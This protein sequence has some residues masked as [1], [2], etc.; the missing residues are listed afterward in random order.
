VEVSVPGWRVFPSGALRLDLAALRPHQTDP[1]GY[2]RALGAMLFADEAAGTAYRETLA[3]CQARGTAMRV[4]LRLDPPALHD[5]HWER[6]YAPTADDWE[7]LAATARTPFARSLPAQGWERPPLVTRRPLR[8]LAVIA[9]PAGLE[10]FDLDPIAEAERAALRATLEGLPGVSVTYLETGTARPATLDA[11]RAALA[12]G[13]HLVHLLCHGAARPDGT[14]LYLDGAAGLDRVKRERLLGCFA[15]VAQRPLFCFIAAC[16][17]AR[18][19]RVDG[20]MPL[21][22]ALVRDGSVQ[23]AVAMADRV[24]VATA[25][26]FTTHFY[27]RLLTHGLLDVAT[28]EA[29]ALVQDAWDWGVPVLFSRLPDNQ[30]LDFPVSHIFPAATAHTDRAMDA[31][32]RALAIARG[33]ADGATGQVVVQGLRALLLELS[34]SHKALADVASRL[35]AVSNAADD[36]GPRFEGF[37]LD[38]KSY[39]D[40]ETWT[41]EE[42]SCQ[43]IFD[44]RA[45][46]APLW[47]LLDHDTARQLDS[48]LEVLSNADSTLLLFFR[49]F[50]DTMDAAVEEIK[51][52]VDAGDVEGA[53]RRKRD[54]EAQISPTLRRSKEILQRM[55]SSLGHVAAA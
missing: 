8:L 18:R 43:R 21:G 45:Q 36:F 2:G 39:Y 5:L 47:P 15:A 52:S 27:T 51:A 35:R 22:P 42:T 26:H 46:L 24:G 32:G 16:E 53:I 10:G 31:A 13:F 17:S 48:E 41:D 38:F 34:K 33:H 25:R 14:E 12:E 3:V 54:F 49:E 55:N 4:A 37:Y 11:L 9:S 50:L 6:L 28:N 20:L 44:L 7:P 1:V 40:G 29:R 19:A 23:A 30:L